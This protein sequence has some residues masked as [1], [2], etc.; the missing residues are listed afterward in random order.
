MHGV[1]AQDSNK[2]GLFSKLENYAIF[3]WL[4]KLTQSYKD[5][6]LY[7]VII[8]YQACCSACFKIIKS[9]SYKAFGPCTKHRVSKKGG[10]NFLKFSK[11]KLIRFSFFFNFIISQIAPQVHILAD[12]WKAVSRW[13][14]SP[15]VFWCL[16]WTK[17]EKI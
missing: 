9:K 2:V 16:Y 6:V 10:D 14:N 4:C 7:V 11:S 8:F 5:V 17:P 13:D 12:F 1:V 15:F 3:W